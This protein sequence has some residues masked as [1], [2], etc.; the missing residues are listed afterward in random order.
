LLLI[1]GIWAIDFADQHPECEVV[2]IDLSPLQP[3]YVPPNLQFEIDD[4]EGDTWGYADNKKF[5][6]IHARS[7][8]GTVKD[9]PKLIKNI[10]E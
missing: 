3:T 10:Y 9:W 5:D 6:F 4:F 2:G 7:L 8:V 1:A